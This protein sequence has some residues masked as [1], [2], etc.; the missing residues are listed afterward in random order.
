M[1]REGQWSKITGKPNTCQS[2]IEGFRV[3][4]QDEFSAIPGWFGK[5]SGEINAFGSKYLGDYVTN[6]YVCRH[7]CTLWISIYT[8]KDIYIAIQYIHV[9]HIPAYIP[10]YLYTYMP[11]YLHIHIHA[12]ADICVMVYIYIYVYQECM[13][14]KC[15]CA[16]IC[17]CT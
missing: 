17:T 7:V 11:T 15:I 2:L 8:D 1:T 6:R 3:D 10:T 14:Y 4:F 16:K 13:L 12:H 9:T 5:A